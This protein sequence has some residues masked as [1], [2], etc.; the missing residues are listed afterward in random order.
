MASAGPSLSLPGCGASLTHRPKVTF[1]LAVF[2]EQKVW[3]RPY[4]SALEEI[5][6]GA[7]MLTRRE[8][9]LIACMD[10]I[11]DK[12]DWDR[13]VF[14]D[15][16]VA[17]WRIE[18][19]TPA[20]TKQDVT[21]SSADNKHD[22]DKKNNYGGARE[23]LSTTAVQDDGFSPRMFD[24]AIAELRYKARL[25]PKINCIEALD[26][27]WKSDTIVPSSLQANLTAAIAR[28]ENLPAKD[29]DWHPGSDG[30]VLDIVHP[31][32]YPLIY[33]NSRILTNSLHKCGVKDCLSWLGQGSL[34]VSDQDEQ[35]FP[36]APYSTYFQWLPSE[37]QCSPEP[38]A[39]EIRSYINN[40]HPLQQDTAA[41]YP[42]IENL[43]ECAIP[44]WNRTLSP[45]KTKT[46]L[47][48]RISDWSNS[49]HGHGY[50]FD[51]DDPPTQESD[52]ED[53]DYEAR[54]EDW[55]DTRSIAHP[56]ADPKGFREPS[57]RIREAY[58][59]AFEKT[60]RIEKYWDLEPLVDLR[61]D[62]FGD[63]Q[64]GRLQIIVKVANIHLT[65]EKPRFKGGSWHVEGMAN[66]S[67]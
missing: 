13:K 16:I 26:G 37:V 36:G 2:N 15:G 6:E 67:M 1:P 59:E 12:P 18:I 42:L 62:D 52:E 40:L 61:R 47:P 50:S 54:Y 53:D 25:L 44:L 7:R 41:L 19:V 63:G 49:R 64:K 45:F 20:P 28:L 55:R 31:S 56:D 35:E 17:K 10:M 5:R 65:P 58:A 66:E 51:N 33:G 9:D 46:I 60:N 4:I 21:A 39:V 43:I 30:Q 8:T 22:T 24:W 14:D 34:L 29:L 11:T 32:I 57:Q 23:G 38:E 27:V 48:A 3:F